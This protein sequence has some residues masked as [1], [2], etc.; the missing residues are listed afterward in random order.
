MQKPILEY[1]LQAKD[2]YMFVAQPHKELFTYMSYRQGKARRGHVADMGIGKEQ[3]MQLQERIF[4][5]AP[6]N[7]S[8]NK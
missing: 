5:Q 3:C 6:D 1:G 2:R 7:V 4:L 8:R